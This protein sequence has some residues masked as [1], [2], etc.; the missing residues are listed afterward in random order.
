M[1]SGRKVLVLY[2]KRPG[3]ARGGELQR[4]EGPGRFR[5][6]HLKEGAGV[7]G[8]RGCYGIRMGFRRLDGGNWLPDSG[9]VGSASAARG[10]N[11]SVE[12]AWDGVPQR[13]T[14]CGVAAGRT[15]CDRAGA[16]VAFELSC[17]RSSDNLRRRTH[18]ELSRRE[19][20]DNHHGSAAVRAGPETRC[21]GIGGRFGSGHRGR[22]RAE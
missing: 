10:E 8:G 3:R 16:R 1:R 5:Y 20:L 7:C 22:E 19:A 2:R 15:G 21:N 14:G 12:Q 13:T 18:V 6:S 9:A 17:R 4:A 11:A